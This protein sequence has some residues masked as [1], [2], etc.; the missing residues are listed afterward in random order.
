M[1]KLADLAWMQGEWRTTQANAIVD[2]TW[3]RPE[4]N[5][6]LG[7]GQTTREGRLT[8]AE[9]LMIQETSKGVFL[10]IRHFGPA[11]ADF[12]DGV[13]LKVEL[14]R[15]EPGKAWFGQPGAEKP[16]RITYEREG[17]VLRAR[18]DSFRLDGSQEMFRFQYT[19]RQP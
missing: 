11:L 10:S 17:D 5:T 7:I 18:V 13:N 14:T 16:R 19:R 8:M 3:F 4:G 12:D 6:M 9:F 15:C 1:F 2:E